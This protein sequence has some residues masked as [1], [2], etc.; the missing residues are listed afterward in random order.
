M[1]DKKNVA[2]RREKTNSFDWN[3]RENSQLHIVIDVSSRFN[4]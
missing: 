3:L 1:N 2:K 4:V